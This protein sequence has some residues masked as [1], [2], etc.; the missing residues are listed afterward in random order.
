MECWNNAKIVI[1]VFNT[2][3]ISYCIVSL[4]MRITYLCFVA[5]SEIIP[6]T[7]EFQI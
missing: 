7:Q 6:V 3:A 1:E 5:N 2:R 4:I